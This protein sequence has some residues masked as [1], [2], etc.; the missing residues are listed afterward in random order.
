MPL[1]WNLGLLGSQVR[2]VIKPRKME[3]VVQLELQEWANGF[4]TQNEPWTRALPRE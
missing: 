3:A 2:T 4:D 1:S